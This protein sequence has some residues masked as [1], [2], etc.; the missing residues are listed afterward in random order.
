MKKVLVAFIVLLFFASCS[1]N[2][3]V[4]TRAKGNILSNIEL[5]YKNIDSTRPVDLKSGERVTL[6]GDNFQTFYVD[7][8]RT[9]DAD[10]IQLISEMN[11]GLKVNLVFV[12][13]KTEKVVKKVEVPKTG[14][15][16]YRQEDLVT[17]IYDRRGKQVGEKRVRKGEKVPYG[18]TEYTDTSLI[19]V[20]VDLGLL[21][22]R[23]N[24]MIVYTELDYSSYEMDPNK[25]TREFTG[26]ELSKKDHKIEVIHNIDYREVYF[27]TP[28]Q[29]KKIKSTIIKPAAE[30]STSDDLDFEE[31][32]DFLSEPKSDS[33]PAPATSDDSLDIDI[34]I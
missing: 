25:N 13:S 12:D 1:Q 6:D 3:V 7:L 31:E 16:G 20:D 10:H 18:D 24:D 33:E 4:T 22:S 19:P 17:Y 34:D 21:A 15:E 11:Q 14:I 23:E 30:A 27:T 26:D 5:K 32:D 8:S 9:S 29:S 2:V 28:R